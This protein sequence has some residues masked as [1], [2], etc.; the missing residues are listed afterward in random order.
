MTLIRL[1]YAS[2]PFGF[3]DLALMGILNTAQQN[4]K[5]DGI[6]GALICREDV[7]VQWL[8]GPREAVT[9]RYGRIV[10]DDRHTDVAVL[11][12]EDTQ[13]RMFPTW[14]MRHDPAQSWMWSP[15]DISRGCLDHVTRDEVLEMF[16]RVA[17]DLPGPHSGCPFAHAPPPE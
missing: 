14:A 9:H 1:I 11:V 8:E 7:Y 4:N 10:Q 15:Q 5:R 2:R 6:T 3:D 13:E 16:T 12:N 17:R